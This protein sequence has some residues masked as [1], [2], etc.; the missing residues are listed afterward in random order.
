MAGIAAALKADDD[1][2]FLSQ[3]IRYLALSL[4]TPVGSNDRSNHSISSLYCQ[5]PKADDLR[6]LQY[7][8]FYYYA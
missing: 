8:S 6:T 5:Q 3:H 4:I 1:I 2:R 7:A